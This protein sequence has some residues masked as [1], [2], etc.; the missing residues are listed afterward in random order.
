MRK[1]TRIMMIVLAF[2]L[3]SGSAQATIADDDEGERLFLR[4]LTYNG[5]PLQDRRWMYQD[6][7]TKPPGYDPESDPKLEQ[8]DKYGSHYGDLWAQCQLE[9]YGIGFFMT[10]D[11]P[12]DAEGHH[13]GH[14]YAWADFFVRMVTGDPSI[15]ITDDYLS[16]MLPAAGE[17]EYFAWVK[18]KD[19]D[20]WLNV[21]KAPSLE[22]ESLARLNYNRRVLVTGK[23]EREG[24]VRVIYLMET[25]LAA[26][27]EGELTV[28]TT[29]L[30]GY[31]KETYLEKDGP[32][33][34]RL[35][36][37]LAGQP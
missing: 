12:F 36:V 2:C 34:P 22:A 33:L 30:T 18:T 21:R 31:V 14:M 3:F 32:L 15:T 23:A 25:E 37:R 9:W 8:R 17:G 5:Q 20:S 28:I 29:P 10:D 6:V 13:D 7:S 27:A 19:R 24:W 16:A 11:V 4:G 35:S 1:V 26:D